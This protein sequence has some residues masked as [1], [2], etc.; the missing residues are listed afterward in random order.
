MYSRSGTTGNSIFHCRKTNACLGTT[1]EFG[2]SVSKK[3][4]GCLSA[5]ANFLFLW[6][7]W[8]DHLVKL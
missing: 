6:K 1:I 7:E 3:R 2:I 5:A 4:N 8:Y